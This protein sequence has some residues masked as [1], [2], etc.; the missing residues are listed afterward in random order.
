MLQVIRSADRKTLLGISSDM[1]ELLQKAR[2]GK[3]SPA[4]YQGGTFSLSNL[5]MFG[6]KEFTAIINPPQAG[7]LAAGAGQLRAVVKNGQ[8][9]TATVMTAVIAFDH[10]AI[11]GAVGAGLLATLKQLLENPLATLISESFL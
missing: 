2:A 1:N 6:V 4:E 5:G 9:S 3:L 10:R 7:I 8:L 11:D